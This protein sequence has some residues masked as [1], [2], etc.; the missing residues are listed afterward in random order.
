VFD[1]VD[2]K[3]VMDP[4]AKAAC[5]LTY[6]EPTMSPAAGFMHIGN[7]TGEIDKARKLVWRVTSRRLERR[8]FY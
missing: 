2:D 3:A 8:A 6:K 5:R 4:G 7:P 1:R